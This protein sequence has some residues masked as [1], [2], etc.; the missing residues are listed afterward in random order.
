V[1]AEGTFN[2]LDTCVTT[3]ELNRLMQI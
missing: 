2:F 1:K 3:A